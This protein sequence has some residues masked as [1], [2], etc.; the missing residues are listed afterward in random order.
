MKQLLTIIAAVIALTVSAQERNDNTIIIPNF[1]VDR[2]DD[3]ETHLVMSFYQF[4][5]IDKD[6]VRFMTH[7]KPIEGSVYAQDLQV[8]VYGMLIGE[9]LVLYATY[10]FHGTGAQ[11]HSGRADYHRRPLV[12]RRM[13]F[14]EL[15]HTIK[16]FGLPI[17]YEQR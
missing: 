16:A 2:I 7:P 13:A 10:T 9:D 6:N 11:R 8:T 15:N 4:Q 14:D 1:P 12:G 17:E 3:F 5:N